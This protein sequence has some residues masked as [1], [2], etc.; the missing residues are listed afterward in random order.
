[1]HEHDYWY[2]FAYWFSQRSAL[3]AMQ[4]A[5]LARAIL[6]VCLSVLPSHSGVLSR[7]MKDTIMRFTASGST[8]ILVSGEV[9]FIRIIAGDHT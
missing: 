3:L 6:S 5:V 1:M 9:K 2:S 8:I 7:R 4:T